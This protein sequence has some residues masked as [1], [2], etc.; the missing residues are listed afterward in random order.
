MK[1]LY[2]SLTL[3]FMLIAQ[4]SFA[5]SFKNNSVLADGKWVKIKVEESGIYELSY[6]Q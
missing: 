4:Y 3:I 5:I 6:Q 2:L 1:R